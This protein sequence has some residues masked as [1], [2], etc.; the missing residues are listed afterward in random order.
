[1]ATSVRLR[2]AAALAFNASGGAQLGRERVRGQEKCEC[3]QPELRGLFLGSTPR[4]REREEG[5]PERA[6]APISP[7]RWREAPA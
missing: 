5:S 7:S 1:M 6:T 4:H 2:A 3:H